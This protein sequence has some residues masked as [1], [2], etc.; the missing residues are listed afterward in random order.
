MRTSLAAKLNLLVISMITLSA[1]AVSGFAFQTV[2]IEERRALLRQGRTIAEVMERNSLLEIYEEDSERLQQTLKGLTTNVD[3]AYIRIMN[4]AGKVLASQVTTQ[5]LAVPEVRLDDRVRNGAIVTTRFEASNGSAGF[6]N[7]LAPVRSVTEGRAGDLL[8][9]LKPGARIPR[10]IGYLQIGLSNRRASARS[11]QLLRSAAVFGA[12]FVLTAAALT[13][14]LTRKLTQPVRRLAALTRDISDGNFDQ[15]VEASTR[16][17]VGE[18]ALA[19]KVMLERLN[20]YRERVRHHERTLEAQVKDRTLEL[21]QR[22]EEAVELARQAEAASLAKSQFLANMSHEIRTPMNGVLGMTEL[23][24]E[25]EMTSRQRGFTDT[26]QHSARLLLGLINDILDFSR[27]EAGKLE[28]EPSPFDLLDAVEEVTSLLA[29]PAQSKGLEVVCFVDD[30]VPHSVRADVVRLRQILTNLVG[31]AVK[32][33]E[34]G[35]VMLRVSRLAD[36]S[37]QSTSESKHRLSTVE[38][39]VSDT[40]IGIPG[41]ERDR[42]FQSFTQADGSMARRFGGTGLGLAICS[43][44]VEL[45]GG[46]IGFDSQEGSGSRFWVRI[47]L[48]ILENADGETLWESSDLQGLRVLVVDDNATNRS[49]LMHHLS[50]WG[51]EAVEREDGHSALEEF[52][53]A[54]DQGTPFDL[55]ILDMMMPRMTGIGLAWAIRAEK[56]LP[57]PRLVIL[58]S[59]GGSMTTEEERKLG[60]AVR[61]TK[62]TRKADLYNALLEA[63]GDTQRDRPSQPSEGGQN[64]APRADLGAHVLLAEDND[65]NLLVALAMLEALGCGVCSAK[66]GKEALKQ[67]EETSF[68]LVF[69]DCQMP[70]MDGFAATREIRARGTKSASSK[71]QRLPIVALTAHAM[72]RDRKA[73]LEAGMDDYLSKPYTKEDLRTVLERWVP[74][75]SQ[76]TSVEAGG[77]RG[78]ENSRPT[79]SARL[80]EQTWTD[81]RAL[82]R[83]SNVQGLVSRMIDTYLKSS[84]ELARHIRDAVQAEDAANMARASHTLKSSSAQVGALGLAALCKEIEARGKTGSMEG[85]QELLAQFSEELEAVHEDLVARSFGASDG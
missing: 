68:D 78:V 67:I 40:G 52:R 47:P 6:V 27:A 44:L 57:Q 51:A 82:E 66:N 74:G 20:E 49:I 15:R 11:A 37:D 22:T 79:D 45:M 19:L 53:R 3:V 25:T 26:V 7:L 36:V 46:Q 63:M 42:I 30:D 56:S 80:D 48:E 8:A 13:L 65:V 17:E 34:H 61:L 55:A 38:F 2:L 5:G 14:F 70:T 71:E 81:L 1:I 21:H 50:S 77:Q 39:L 35:E 18:L 73:C 59:V 16:D 12:L 76:K 54:A 83:E 28:L 85:A 43:Q 29:E 72:E 32:F 9:T 84:E 58:T 69:M 31:N 60:I 23:L 64:E 33:T 10:V 4:A 62:P 75:G 41:G 24:L